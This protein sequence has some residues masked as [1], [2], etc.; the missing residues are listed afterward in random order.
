MTTHEI[1]Q[2][3]GITKQALIY[4][5]KEG[6]IN[7]KRDENNYR[8]YSSSDVDILRL[9]LLLR[10]MEVPIDEIKLILD[11]KLSIRKALE[12]KKIS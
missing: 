2:M 7:P 12:T 1:E 6:M 8:N 3:L 5:E 11:G 4:Y 9:I 10:S